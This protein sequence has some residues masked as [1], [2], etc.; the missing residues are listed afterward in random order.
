METAL[1]LETKL[2]EADILV[3]LSGPVQ[4]HYCGLNWVPR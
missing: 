1:Y 2:R 4:E 3:R